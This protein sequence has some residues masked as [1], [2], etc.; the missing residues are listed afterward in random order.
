M[1]AAKEELGHSHHLAMVEY[2]LQTD[3]GPGAISGASK[4]HQQQA[5]TL[6]EIDV[7]IQ[8]Y[9]LPVFG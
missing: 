4:Q 5:Q 7:A 1:S 3:G 6:S 2:L 8:L 9:V